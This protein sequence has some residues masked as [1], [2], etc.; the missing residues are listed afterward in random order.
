MFEL[1]GFDYDDATGKL[2]T[3]VGTPAGYIL[4]ADGAGGATW[5]AP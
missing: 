5:V 2:I 1:V 4:T 3:P